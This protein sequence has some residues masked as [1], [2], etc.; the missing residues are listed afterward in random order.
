MA[1]NIIAVEKTAMITF[2]SLVICWGSFLPVRDQ[3]VELSQIRTKIRLT[4]VSVNRGCPKAESCLQSLESV[5]LVVA[6][7]ATPSTVPLKK[8]EGACLHTPP[9]RHLGEPTEGRFDTP[10]G[11]GIASSAVFCAKFPRFRLGQQL[12]LR[13]IVVGSTGFG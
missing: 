5:M 7:L 1:V 12:K 11:G 10:P 8:K 6:I 3:R 13:E 9:D 2:I 4:S